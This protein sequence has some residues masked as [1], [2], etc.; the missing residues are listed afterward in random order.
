ME[1]IGLIP[2]AGYA[3]RLGK[4]HGSKEM[5]PVNGGYGI[6]PVCHS[7]IRQ[8]E[9]AGIKKIVLVTRKDKIDLLHHVKFNLEFNVEIVTVI[10]EKTNSTIESICAAYELIREKEVYLGFPDMIMSPANAMSTLLKVKG[11]SS[12]NV[13]LGAF[14]ASD[15]RKVDLID[16]GLNNSLVDIVIKNSD[17]CYK[18]AWIIA[19]W[20]ANFTEY[21]YN[22]FRIENLRSRD[23]EIY[24]GN[25]FL[26]YLKSGHDIEVHRYKGGYLDIGTPEE[27]ARLR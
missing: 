11:Y 26:S 6:E 4:F 18:Y 24:I 14:P 13:V 21:L 17:C 2:A 9:S 15:A 27:L 23:K 1:K 5:I 25:I 19:C 10:L 8:F 3:R 7:L 16:I 20:D 22:S 12:A